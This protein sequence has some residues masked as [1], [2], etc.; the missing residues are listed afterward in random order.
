MVKDPFMQNRFMT[1]YGVIPGSEKVKEW[2]GVNTFL[3]SLPTWVS[4]CQFKEKWLITT[5]FIT[6]KT[7]I[8]CLID[9]L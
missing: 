4:S 1:P 6:L 2:A 3:H 8:H 5:V 7:T 9:S